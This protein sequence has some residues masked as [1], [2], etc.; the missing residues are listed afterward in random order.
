MYQP[1]STYCLPVVGSPRT[2]ARRTEPLYAHVPDRIATER[3]RVKPSQSAYARRTNH[4]DTSR[5]N[6][7]TRIRRTSR[8]APNRTALAYR[9]RNYTL[10][11]YSISSRN[12]ICDSPRRTSPA[13]WRISSR[14]RCR[15][16]YCGISLFAQ[17]LSAQNPSRTP[18][19]RGGLIQPNVTV[20]SAAAAR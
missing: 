13:R 5:T 3:T 15:H 2:S 14:P 4:L 1:N 11:S 16:Q 20:S 6:R 18:K 8:L 9:R 12:K 17:T 7:P 10:L 19:Q